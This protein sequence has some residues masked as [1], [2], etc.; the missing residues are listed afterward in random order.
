MDKLFCSKDDEYFYTKPILL[1]VASEHID[2][3]K[4]LKN[5]A[6]EALELI[7]FVQSISLSH[8]KR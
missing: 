2:D 7:V 8:E 3:M 1:Q 5:V 6:L 4:M